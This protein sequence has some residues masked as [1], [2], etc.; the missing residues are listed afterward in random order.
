MYADKNAPVTTQ[1]YANILWN[2]ESATMR[3]ATEYTLRGQCAK[4]PHKKNIMHYHT[5]KQTSFI[6]STAQ[7]TQPLKTNLT[8]PP[9]P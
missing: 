3:I 5:S 2:S 6:A 7:Q 9:V 4:Y 1:I 8:K